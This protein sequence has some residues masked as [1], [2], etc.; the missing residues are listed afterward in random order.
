M[1]IEKQD[2]TIKNIVQSPCESEGRV[3]VGAGG[4]F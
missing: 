1:F 4:G 2:R 3:V